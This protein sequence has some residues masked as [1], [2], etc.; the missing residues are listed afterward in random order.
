MAYRDK[1]EV[2]PLTHLFVSSSA[3]MF[4]FL[5]LSVLCAVAAAYQKPDSREGKLWDPPAIDVFPDH[6]AAARS[7]KKTAAMIAA[8]EKLFRAR[9]NAA[10]GAGRPAATGDSK[11]T[12]RS[13]RPRNEFSRTSGPDAASCAACH[14]QPVTGGSGDFVANAFVGAHF[15]DPPTLSIATETTSERNTIGM[16]GSGVIEMLAR[17][18]SREL[19]ALRDNGI[20][21]AGLLHA[22]QEVH[23][24]SK[25]VDFGSI[26]IRDDGTID[27]AKLEGVDLDL[28]V[29]PFGS[30]G[31]AASLREFTIAALNQHHGIQAIERFG[32][33]RTGHRDFDEDGF[34]VEFSIGQVS[35]LVLFQALLPAPGRRLARD[36]DQCELEQRGE[37]L[38]L[39]TGCEVCHK[40]SLP[41]ESSQFEEPNPYNRPGTASTRDLEKVIR[42]ELPLKRHGGVRR[43]RHGT[44]FVAAYS[45]LRRHR[46]CDEQVP[47]L[48]NEKRRQDNVPTD[49][50]MTAKLWDLATS[51]P[52]CH[53]GDCA[54]VS[55][56]ILAHGAEGLTTRNRFLALVESDKRALVAFLLSL[57]REDHQP[58]QPCK[59]RRNRGRS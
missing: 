31:V 23:L 44:L 33:E 19:R 20:K 42:V 50:F 7:P 18:M 49:M 29:R 2:A 25:G 32:W 14:N 16:F 17:E 54:T 40:S 10:D 52:Y 27:A 35:A 45:D 28:V 55:E 12:S 34:E 21:R 37:R 6:D 59:H 26:T 51:G 3:R 22:A 9:F 24:R 57:G 11:P 13:L 41:L 38:F 15:A 5:I 39:E 46:I 53:R 47:F 1:I 8:G 48:C 36:A 43:T 30:K 56:A 4:G 58:G